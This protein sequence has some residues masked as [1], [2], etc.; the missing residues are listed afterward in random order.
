VGVAAPRPAAGRAVPKPVLEFPK[1]TRL[2]DHGHARCYEPCV[3]CILHAIL[4]MQGAPII[5]GPCVCASCVFHAILRMRGAPIIN[6]NDGH[7][8]HSGIGQAIPRIVVGVRC[9]SGGHWDIF[10]ATPIPLRI[11][12][13]PN[14]LAASNGHWASCIGQA[15][16]GIIVGIRCTSGFGHR[17]IFLAIVLRIQDAPIFA[18]SNGHWASC[19]CQAVAGII[20]GVRC[21]GLCF[22][23][24]CWRSIT[25]VRVSAAIDVRVL[26]RAVIP[27]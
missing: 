13:A 12:D 24:S 3:S 27:T 26:C 15:V 10:L 6:I 11:Q 23:S 2:A 5:T 17:D 18:T 7:C 8:C 20:V 25:E 16:A 22:V 9:A 1:P 4:R 21:R 14:I 19:I